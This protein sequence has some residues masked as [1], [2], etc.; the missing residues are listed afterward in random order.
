MKKTSICVLLALGLVMAATGCGNTTANKATGQTNPE[1]EK[2][3]IEQKETSG[4]AES[5]EPV[6]FTWMHHLQE[7]GKQEWVNWLVESYQ[8][9]NPNIKVNVELL[10]S[11]QYNTMLK[12]KIASGDAPMIF[13]LGNQ[14]FTEFVDSG[15]CADVTDMEGMDNYDKTTV[16]R[17]SV[18]GKVYGV[19]FDKNAYCTFYNKDVFEKYGLEVPS[20]V[21]E[22]Q[23]VCKVL[24]E[25]GVTPIAAPFSEL[26]C[27]R[28]YDMVLTDVQC[29]RDNIDWFTQKMSMEIPF[30][31]DQEFK[32]CAEWF[33]SLKPYWGDDPF[34]TSWNDAMN[35]VATGKA[36]MTVNGSW[37][38]DGI[39]SLN[40][41]VNLG[42]FAWPTSDEES[43]SVMV[44]KPG[45]SYCVY[46]N[47][48]DPEVLAAAKDFFTYLCSK[49][50]AE[51]FAEHAHGLVGC[52]IDNTSDITA[53]NEINAY[54]GDSLYVEPN[55]E[56]FTTE[57]QNT[58]FETLQAYAMINSFDVDAFCAELDKKFAA[59]Q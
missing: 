22:L 59:L 53:L 28:Y 5:A 12:T 23:E 41:D 11:D 4:Q 18:D 43:G 1:T 34:G 7:E 40:P 6:T 52:Q 57:A 24:L 35:M 13:D 27:L 2:Q 48:E 17:S 39:M 58:V 51:Y 15:Y 3:S 49:E 8:E 14:L 36:A 31:E 21:T 46:N 38:V 55:M 10:P 30:S 26:W 33:Y 20:T 37:A 25:N 45:S 54:Q 42:A 29:C 19:C 50:S 32:D 44:V 47:T 16:E 56:V 9:A